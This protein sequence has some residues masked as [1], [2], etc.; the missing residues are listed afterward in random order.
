L[1]LIQKD[2]TAI[3][4]NMGVGGSVK[5]MSCKHIL[6]QSGA[7]ASTMDPA[8]IKPKGR[9]YPGAF[10]TKKKEKGSP[11]AKSGK[12]KPSTNIQEPDPRVAGPQVEAVETT[13][14]MP[15]GNIQIRPGNQFDVSAGTGG[16]RLMSGGTNTITGMGNTNIMS[17]AILV[18]GSASVDVIGRSNVTL[19][20]AQATVKSPITVITGDVHIQGTTIIKGNLHIEGNLTVGGTAE[21]NQTLAVTGGITTF[22]DVFSP[23]CTLNTH[24]HPQVSGND[25]GGGPNTRP[26]V[27]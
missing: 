4:K 16:I 24:K 12:G 26:S 8:I 27:R 19:E 7:A 11:N 20:G 25:A 5:I 14:N 23:V 6:L 13:A 21:M 1:P 2:L 10:S 18:Q 22:A 17:P 9:E 15:F 3:E